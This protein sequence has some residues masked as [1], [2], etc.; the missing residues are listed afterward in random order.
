MIQK[1]KRKPTPGKSNAPFASKVAEQINKTITGLQTKFTRAL[2]DKEKSLTVKQ[3]KWAL[4][5][6]CSGMFL[7]S[8][9]WLYEGL[10]DKNRYTIPYMDQQTITR[11]GN[12]KLPD[13]LDLKNLEEFR[14]RQQSLPKMND[15]ANY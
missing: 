10:F 5:I 2:S 8:G 9:Y 13:S 14:K 4:F 6:F 1:L 12:I 15:S 7:I 3:K 11:P